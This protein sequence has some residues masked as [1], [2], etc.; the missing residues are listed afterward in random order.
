MGISDNQELLTTF[1]TGENSGYR[2]GVLSSAM[3]CLLVHEEVTVA[4]TTDYTVRET[5]AKD[6]PSLKVT[7]ST[8]DIKHIRDE[9]GTVYETATPVVT[10]F[11]ADNDQFALGA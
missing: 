8:L 4:P 6:E 10:D 9:L 2:T 1:G 7:E 3:E 11:E 5:E